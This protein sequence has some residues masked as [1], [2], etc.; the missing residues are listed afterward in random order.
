[1]NLEKSFTTE[2]TTLLKG[3]SKFERI[4][5]ELYHPVWFVKYLVNVLGHEAAI[6][7]LK[8][9]N[10]PKKVWARVN[11]LVTTRD[12]VIKELNQENIPVEKD[13]TFFDLIKVRKGPLLEDGARHNVNLS[14]VINKG[15]LFIQGKASVAVSH[16]LAPQPHETVV[17][18]CA[19][20]GMKTSHLCQL[21]KNQ[22][23]IIAIDV[24]ELRLKRLY[25]LKLQVNGTIINLILGDSCYPSL[26]PEM[27]DKLLIDAPCSSTGIIG[28]YP[29]QKWLDPSQIATFSRLQE[30]LILKSLPLLK[31][32]GIGV[33]SVCSL[34]EQEGEQHLLKLKKR[35]N[36]RL[37]D[38]GYGSSGYQRE[39]YAGLPCRRFFP[40]LH[41]TAGFFIIKFEK[42]A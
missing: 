15:W 38:P 11:S 10:Q 42:L 35:S 40:H 37:L 26:K 16:I 30:E 27:A 22:G 24:S 2:F 5:L 6:K 17:D 12:E 20:P 4:A 19:A 1:K 9:N 34:M 3:K 13:E 41:E 14:S 28:M 8:A 39:E 36:I 18:V 32:G 23:K 33:Y 21:M 31:P 25:E 7:L 29:D